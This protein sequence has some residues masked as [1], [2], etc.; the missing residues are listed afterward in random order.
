MQGQAPPRN[1]RRQDVLPRRR[2]QDGSLAVER[3]HGNGNF[4]EAPPPGGA[5]CDGRV[6]AAPPQRPGFHAL[7][8]SS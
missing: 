4:F 6:V 5:V 7:R 1:S 8:R 2:S 3:R